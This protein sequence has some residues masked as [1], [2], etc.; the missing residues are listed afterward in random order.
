MV[1]KWLSIAVKAAVSAALIGFLF[2][3]VDWS[4]VLKRL[5]QLDLGEGIVCL[6]ILALQVAL[7][8]Q[9]WRMIARIIGV[10][11]GFGAA[12]RM[13]VIG[14]F[15]NQ[16]LPSSIGGD[17]VRA[18][19]VTREGASFGRG[20][21]VVLSDRVFALLVLVAVMAATLP[22]MYSRVGDGAARTGMTVL[23]IGGLAG[24]AVFL[25]V[26]EG[27]SALLQRWRITR[28]LGHLAADFRRLFNNLPTVAALVAL[29]A[30]VHIGTVLAVLALADGLDIEVGFVDCLVLMPP[31]LL[32]TMIPLSIAGWGVRE[33]AMVIGFGFVGVSPADAL[34]LS[35]TLGIAQLLI[36]LPGGLLW[37]RG[38][39]KAPIEDISPR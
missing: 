2:A 33:G 39:P 8:G 5:A 26:G 19:L 10:V 21:A 25:V 30:I 13:L 15:F 23:A 7:T 20:V 28:P 24:I 18:W 32:A 4:M 38:R 16:T 37:L 31:I 36:G 17:A 29:S 6:A 12:V 27:V 3:S 14:L 35:V 11:F 34:A 22:L 1:R 9:R